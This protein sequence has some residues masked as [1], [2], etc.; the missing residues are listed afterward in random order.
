MLLV[1]VILM[2]PACFAFAE[3]QGETERQLAA[4]GDSVEVSLLTCDPGQEAYSLYGHTAL[5]YHALRSGSDWTFNYGVFNFRKPFFALR[6]A[7]GLTDYELGALP[8]GL[9]KQEYE[10]TRRGVTEQVLNLTP[11]EKLLLIAALEDNLKPENVVYRYNFFYD[12]CTTR[13]RD[14]VER[15]IEGRVQ[16]PEEGRKEANEAP[17]WRELIHERTEGHAWDALGNDLCLGFK[18]DQATTWRERQFLPLTLMDDFDRAIIVNPDGTR[19]PLVKQTRVALAFTVASAETNPVSP[20]LCGFLLLAATIGVTVRER[21]GRKGARVFDVAFMAIQGFVGCAATLLLFSQHP[22]TSTNLQA[23][24]LN[25]LPL[26]FAYK[27]ARGRSTRYW[28]WM[29]ALCIVFLLGAFVQT[30]AQGMIF[31]ALSL[32]IRCGA[33]TRWW[34]ARLKVERPAATSPK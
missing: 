17:T 32:L 1:A 3:S 23:L 28:E 7:L 2:M 34:H 9:F 29:G 33:H 15:C 18:A 11:R 16:Y 25:P 26:V 6:F 21:R 24:L 27:V 14:I 5:R 19:R 22:T 10:R 13:A 12:N 30:Y 8:M 20:M 4:I 31:V